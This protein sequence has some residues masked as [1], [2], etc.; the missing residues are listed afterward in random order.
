MAGLPHP[1]YAQGT[2]AAGEA[3]VAAGDLLSR[4]INAW[5]LH[6]PDNSDGAGQIRTLFLTPIVSTNSVPIP[7]TASSSDNP[8][9]P[10]NWGAATE[11]SANGNVRFKGDLSTPGFV[12]IGQ[13]ASIGNVACATPG[14]CTGMLGIN[15]LT[16]A[17]GGRIGAREGI[18]V[19]GAAV[20]WPDYVFAPAYVLR[21]LSEVAQFIAANQHLPEVPSA[22][23]VQAEGVEVVAL[24]ALLLKKVEELTL[25]LIQLEKANAALAERVRVLEH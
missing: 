24:E 13:K 25:Y 15:R 19:V 23:Q 20:A 3:S 7:D 1:A 12:T 18:H 11:F 16:L 9:T 8:P 21:P 2:G 17:V 22:A 4:G 14:S 5:M 10:W 6:T